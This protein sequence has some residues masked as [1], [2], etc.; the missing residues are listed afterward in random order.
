M[1]LIKRHKLVFII[2]LVVLLILGNVFLYN[3]T[4]V[5]A[6]TTTP[7]KQQPEYFVTSVHRQTFNA[8]GH[9][10]NTLT[11]DYLEHTHHNGSTTF[12]AP[13]ITI[14]KEDN[15]WLGNADKGTMFETSPLSAQA[16]SKAEEFLWLQGNVVLHNVSGNHKHADEPIKINTQ[17][18]SIFHNQ[19]II[20]G[21]ELITLTK[22]SNLI[23]AVG[24]EFNLANEHLLL[25]NQVTSTILPRNQ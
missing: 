6:P 22:G 15:L 3:F 18:L 19:D 2:S 14:Y 17:S 20:R 10:V 12:I 1:N 8:E 13:V 25:N 16:T 24:L 7:N 5:T 11:S 23:T 21:Q 9:K 4:T